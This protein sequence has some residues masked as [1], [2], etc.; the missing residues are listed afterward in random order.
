M[1]LKASIKGEQPEQKLTHSFYFQAL[2]PA[3]L[4]FLFYL[5]LDWLSFSYYGGS[6]Q[7]NIAFGLSLKFGFIGVLFV[8]N[9]FVLLSYLKKS[10]KKLWFLPP[11][12]F[13]FC[14]GGDFLRYF[15]CSGSWI[16]IS[17]YWKTAL[18]YLLSI[19]YYFGIILILF[20]IWKATYPFLKRKIGPNWGTLVF[21]GVLIP[22]F[23]FFANP[24]DTLS[25]LIVYT[26]GTEDRGLV[27][28]YEGLSPNEYLNIPN[29]EVKLICGKPQIA[30]SR[31]FP[32]SFGT[33]DYSLFVTEKDAKV[34]VSSIHFCISRAPN[35]MS[36]S[37]DSPVG[38]Y[39]K[40]VII[41]VCDPYTANEIINKYAASVPLDGKW[42]KIDKNHYVFKSGP[43]SVGYPS[44]VHFVIRKCRNDKVAV[45]QS[46]KYY[47]DLIESFRCY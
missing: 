3:F 22:I 8:F 23:L 1:A 7:M 47:P 18:F 2:F 9:F 15:Y 16:I 34:N 21:F 14:M 28:N 24:V 40:F 13:L 32:P 44:E 39:S 30:L 38:I 25:Y 37:E 33:C 41:D 19:F 45:F 43:T 26:G 4:I 10:L 31:G 36:F 42:E 35:I 17:S 5:F 46:V 29:Y 11:M 6:P 20:L 27:I 12:Y